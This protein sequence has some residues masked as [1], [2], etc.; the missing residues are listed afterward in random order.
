MSHSVLLCDRI[1]IWEVVESL[2][3]C[4]NV[5]A[6]I[7]V[8]TINSMIRNCQQQTLIGIF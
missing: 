3:T 2:H 6:A 7:R 4:A 8:L 1:C 5:A